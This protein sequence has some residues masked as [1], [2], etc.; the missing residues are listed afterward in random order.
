MR[1]HNK[2]PDPQK[3]SFAKQPLSQ[4]AHWNRIYQLCIVTIFRT[5]PSPASP[6]SIPTPSPAPSLCPAQLPATARRS[7]EADS[8]VPQFLSRGDLEGSAS[9]PWTLKLTAPFGLSRSCLYSALMKISPGSL[10]RLTISV[11]TA[12]V[13]SPDLHLSL[14]SALPI[15]DL[16]DVGVG[17]CCP[18]LASLLSW[19][20]GPGR[21]SITQNN[22]WGTWIL[23]GWWT[24]MCYLLVLC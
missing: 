1:S 13:G 21:F 2:S 4:D 10:L 5:W 3:P 12:A 7:L 24:G 22:C 20:L 19:K 8:V 11:S 16:E 9:L 6:W 14:G 15:V 18:S 17:L 23:A